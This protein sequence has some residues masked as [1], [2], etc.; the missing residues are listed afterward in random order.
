M[1]MNMNQTE[2]LVRWRLRLE[3]YYYKII[4]KKGAQNT[5]ADCLSRIQLNAL[6]QGNQTT[7]NNPGNIDKDIEKYRTEFIIPTLENPNNSPYSSDEIDEPIL[8]HC[9]H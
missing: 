6:S 9:S 1:N 2:K 4:H 7:T 3:E 8:D 5:N